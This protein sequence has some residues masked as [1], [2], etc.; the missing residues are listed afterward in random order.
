MT[1]RSWWIQSLEQS[2]R[3]EARD[4][5]LPQPAAGQLLVRLHAAALNRGEF[6]AAQGLHKPGAPKPAGMEGAG[7]V[8]ALGPGVTGFQVGDRV[9]GRCPGAFAQYGLIDAREAIPVPQKLSWKEAASIPLAFLVVYDMLIAQG[10][11]QRGEWLLVTGISSGVG[12]AALQTAKVLGANVI[13]TSGSVEKLERLKPLGL[14]VAVRTRGADFA[15]AVMQATGGRGANLAVN[16]VGGTVF[17]ECIRSLA[18]Q[19]R[20]AIV[21]YVDGSLDSQIDLDAVHAKRLSIFGVSN[22]LRTAEQRAATVRGF[23]DD[24]LPA[25]AE[26]RIRPLVDQV[27]PLEELPQ[28]KARMEANLHAG[29]IVLRIG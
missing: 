7:E 3:V 2:T 27:F 4:V 23:V 15:D 20:L 18:F 5:P 28:A 13:G 10:C 6:I 12:V 29:K 14:D 16:T 9:M 8:T 24:V 26:G 22:K 11:L 17:P 25:F 21:G 19:G 1:M